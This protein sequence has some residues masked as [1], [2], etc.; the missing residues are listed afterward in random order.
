MTLVY[1]IGPLLGPVKVGI[2]TNIKARLQTIQ[3]WNPERL[4]VHYS[5]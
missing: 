5:A 4:I 3:N 1:V 2:T